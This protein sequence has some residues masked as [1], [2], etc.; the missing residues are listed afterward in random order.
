MLSF[1]VDT[2]GRRRMNNISYTFCSTSLWL[3]GGL[4]YVHSNAV[5]YVLVGGQCVT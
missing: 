5:G 3:I 1:L 4:Y 2:V